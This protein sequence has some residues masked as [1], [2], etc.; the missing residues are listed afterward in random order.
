MPPG[1]VI[2][3]FVGMIAIIV[4]AYY[5]TYY[6]GKKAS[7][8]SHSRL[9]N[10]NINIVDRFSISKDKSFCLVEINGKVYLIGITNQSM[11]LIDTLDA[12]AFSEAAAE[13]NDKAQWYSAPGGRITGPLTRK[14]AGFIS[15]RM[16]RPPLQ[17]EDTQRAP[18]ADVTPSS[19]ITP[20]QGGGSFSDSLDMAR[21]RGRSEQPDR[22]AGEDSESAEGKE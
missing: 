12:A 7:G 13:H 19:T 22:I 6:I 21:E 14:L 4:A 8:Q 9:R 3:T 1:Q 18:Y 10:K 15:K 17:S 5:V 20:S 16:G 11:T 2:V